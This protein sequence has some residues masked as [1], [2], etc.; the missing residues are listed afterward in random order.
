MQ[1]SSWRD[2]VKFAL[3]RIGFSAPMGGQRGPAETNQSRASQQTM[4][5]RTVSPCLRGAVPD[6]FIGCPRRDD[7]RPSV[8]LVLWT[9]TPRRATSAGGGLVSRASGSPSPLSPRSFF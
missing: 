9:T 7:L 3:S 1:L 4:R 6:L 2:A 8:R 5:T